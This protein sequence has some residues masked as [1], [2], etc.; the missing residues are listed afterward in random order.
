MPTTDVNKLGLV[1]IANRTQNGQL[2]DLVN[3]LVQD[4]PPLAD[5]P[6]LQANDNT[7]HKTTKY[8]NV[9]SAS[10][11]GMYEGVTPTALQTIPTIE[12]L[13]YVEDQVEIDEL[14]LRHV[15]NKAEFRFQEDL[16]HMEGTKQKAGSE[17][18]Y[19]NIATNPRDINGITTRYNALS[20][21][22]VVGCGGTGD[23]L[24]SLLFIMWGRKGV[25]FVYPIGGVETSIVREDM[26]RIRVTDSNGKPYFAYVT[27]FS[28][29]FGLVVRDDR[30]VQR[31]CN[32]ETG[33]AENTIDVDLMIKAKNNLP[34]TRGAVIYCNKETLSMLEIQAKDKP[35]VLHTANDPFG[36]P[37]LRFYD[38]PIRKCDALLATESAVT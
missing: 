18:F 6:W 2:I 33:G 8:A 21:S 9:P 35:N 31:I 24:S 20:L 15:P 38:M 10:V 5:A 14:E 25:H 11:R 4:I 30:A 1:E 28:F 22:N 19:G 3:E 36:N 23:D 27:K 32:I 37:E 29:E 7:S 16:A 34:S 12:H 17:L 26:G 13:C